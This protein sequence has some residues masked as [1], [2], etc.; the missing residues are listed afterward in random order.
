V[1]ELLLDGF[2]D[3]VRFVYRHFPLEEVHPMP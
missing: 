3:R 1:I 2:K